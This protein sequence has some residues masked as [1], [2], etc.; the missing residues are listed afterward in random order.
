MSSAFK[1]VSKMNARV[2]YYY[3]KKDLETDHAADVDEMMPDSAFL[4]NTIIKMKRIPCRLRQLND[5]LTDG[6]FDDGK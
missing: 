6:F 2:N 3:C 4:E 1:M 5:V